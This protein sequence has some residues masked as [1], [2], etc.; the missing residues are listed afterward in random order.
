MCTQKRLPIAQKIT[1]SKRDQSIPEIR[2]IY[3]LSL[4]SY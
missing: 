3:L 2:K 1:L 4:L